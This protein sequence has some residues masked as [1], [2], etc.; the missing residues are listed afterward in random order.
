MPE[1]E[2]A[3]E[4]HGNAAMENA[5]QPLEKPAVSKSGL[6]PGVVLAF[7]IIALLG[8]LIVIAL[9][10]RTGGT[11]AATADLTELQAEANALRGQ[12][13]RERMAMGLRPLE[14]NYEAVEDVAARLRKDADTMVALAGSLQS[15]LAEKDAGLSAKNSELIRSEQLRQSLAAE[16]ARLQAELQRALVSGSD[17]DL[18]RRD[19]AAMKSQRDALAAELATVRRELEAK[20]RGVSADEFADLQRRFEECQRAREFF[21]ARVAELEGELS[22]A[23]LFAS[24]ESELLPAAVELFRSLR[25]LEGKPDSEIATAY[26]SL[27]VSLGANVLHTLNF[28]TGSS[29]LTPADEELIR[30][31]VD[32]VPDGDLVLAIGYASETGNVDANRTLS[33]DR[34]TAAAQSYS[35]LKRPGQLVQA[36]YL[37]QTDRFSSRIPERNQIVEIWRVRKK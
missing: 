7:V 32:E 35:S 23:R 3:I 8:V 25:Q 28:A 29:A 1:E 31:L 9:R 20:G 16:S 17:A 14:G 19:L 21:E 36:V 37:G 15:M 24:S 5:R 10:G 2:S 34:A 26:S 22:K 4:N 18:L 11:G 30:K 27:G 12:L 33:S 6:P 13:N